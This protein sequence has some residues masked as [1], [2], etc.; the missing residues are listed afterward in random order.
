MTT[1]DFQFSNNFAINSI[2]PNK[3][4][5][6]KW[7]SKKLEDIKKFENIVKNKK[8]DKNPKKIKKQNTIISSDTS[9]DNNDIY[10]SYNYDIDY[11]DAVIDY[12]DYDS[13][14]FDLD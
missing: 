3:K 2:Y 8:Q 6:R 10:T 11:D 7:F 13:S 5:N 14:P 9:S 12:S 1:T 4:T